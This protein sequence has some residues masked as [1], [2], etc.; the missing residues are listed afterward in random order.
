MV[1]SSLQSLLEGL[2]QFGQM[3]IQG[4][5]GVPGSCRLRVLGYTR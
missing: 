5:V 3:A 2:V 4:N 1:T